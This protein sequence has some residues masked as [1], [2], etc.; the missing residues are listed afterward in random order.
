MEYHREEV[1]SYRGKHQ[2]IEV[3]SKRRRVFHSFKRW[4]RS[5]N[6]AAYGLYCPDTG[7]HQWGHDI[8]MVNFQYFCD[9]PSLAACAGSSFPLV[10]RSKIQALGEELRE[11]VIRDAFVKA[12]SPKFNTAVMLAELDETLVGVH[13]LLKGAAKAL[14]KDGQAFKYAK[15]FALNSEELWLWYRYALMP[16]MLEVGDLLSAIK[17][18]EQIDRV[19]DGNRLEDQLETGTLLHRG[20][21]ASSPTVWEYPWTM[22]WKAGLGCALDISS[23]FDPAPWGTSAVDVALGIWERTKFSFLIDWLINVGDYIASLRSLE[24]VYAQSYCTY[25][26]EAVTTINSSDRLSFENGNP[27]VKTFLMERIVDLEPPTHPLI[28]RRWR[29]CL[30]TIDLISLTIGM[31]KGILNKRR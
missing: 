25:A 23:R 30:R 5:H 18:Q 20:W 9:N 16:A 3:G 21:T 14:L 28:D 6:A 24:I 11:F 22:E 26:I 31:L 13:K 15:H 27:K 12:K 2:Y 19:Q 4:L 7:Q 29:N 17:P 8:P 1:D 10:A